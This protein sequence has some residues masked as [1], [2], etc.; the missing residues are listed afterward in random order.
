[1]SEFT[2]R[3]RQELANCLPHE[4]RRL[5]RKLEK[6]DGNN[7]VEITAIE[8]EIRQAVLR[9]TQRAASVPVIHFTMD[10]PIHHR[11]DDIR[12]AMEKHQVVVICG[13]TGSGKTT[14][15]PKL[16]LSM[17]RG[18]DGQI[19][20][21]QPRRIAAR[22][23]ATRIAEE[24]ATP[25]G[26]AVGF[27]IRHTD[28]T[29]DNT[30]IKLMTDGI[31]L[32]ELQ[33]DRKLLRYDTLIIDEAHER[34]LNIDFI[35]GYLKQLLPQRP[36]LKVI[37]T[38]A[39]IDVQR[40]SEHFNNAPVI[41]VSGRMYPVEVRYRPVEYEHEDERDD[42]AEQ[43]AI[44]NAVREL[45]Q[46]GHGDILIFL[47]G[48]REIHETTRFLEKQKLPDT[49]VLPLYARLSSARQAKIFQPH[50]RRHIVLATNVAET[51][52]TIPGIRYVIDGGYARISRYSRRAK[53]QQLPV[54][55]ISRAAAEQRKGRCGRVAEGTCIRLYSEDDYTTRPE[56]MDPEIVR[57]NL[58]A[59]I[60]QMK[61]L[62]FSDIHEFP[63]IDPPDPR[64]INDGLRLLNE[65][66]ALN[67]ADDL[68][69]IGKRLARLPLDPRLGR[70]LLAAHELG[71]VSEAVIIVSALSAQD[72]RER[73][74]DAQQQADEAHARFSD[75][76]SDF[77][78]LLNIWTFYHEQ[79][80]K[81]SQNQLRKLCQQ[82]F[83]SYVRIREWREIHKQLVQMLA[84][85]DIHLNSA[86]V[87]YDTLHRALLPGLLSHIAMKSDEREYTGARGI[88]LH[89]FPGSSQF[90]KLPKWIVAAEL[91]ETSKLYARTVAAIQP[92]WLI[93]P[94]AHLLQHEY[95]LPYWD[96]KSQQVLGY[97]KISLF[98]LVLAANQKINYGKVN[99]KEARSIFIRH[100]LVEN[101]LHTR[102]GFLQHNQAIIDGIKQLEHKSRR[103]D[104]YN[105][106]ALADFYDQHLPADVY[107]GPLF[108][109]W[110]GTVV[111]TNSEL[112]YVKRDDIIYHDAEHITPE[113][114]P[115]TLEINRNR[116][117]LNY[118][119]LPGQ[120]E[121]GVN[122]DVP[123]FLLNQITPHH[124][125]R[126][127]P[128][129]LEEK[130]TLMLRSLPKTIRRNLV[131]V[132]DTAKEC[133]EHLREKGGVLTEAL[134]DYLFRSRGVRINENDWQV[135]NMPDHLA[136][137]LRV[138]DENNK[139]LAQGR[140]L[141][142]LQEQ[143][144]HQSQAKFAVISS[145]ALDRDG[146]TRWDFG[147]LPE[148]IR[149]EINQMPV[150]AWP[151]LV[152][153]GNSVSLRSFDTAARAADSMRNGLR[154]LF[155]LEL[156]QEFKYLHKNLPKAKDITFAYTGLGHGEEI[157]NDLINLI[158]DAVFINDQAAIR[159]QTA[160]EQRKQAGAAKLLTEANRLCELVAGILQRHQRLQARLSDLEG[161]IPDG[162]GQD[163]H[164]QLSDLIYPGF[165]HQVDAAQLQHYSRYLEAVD[166]R[167]SKLGYAPDK[168]RTQLNK[169]KPFQDAW[170]LLAHTYKIRSDRDAELDE[171]HFMLEEYRVSLFAQEL[172]T[173][174]TVS[175]E[176]LQKRLDKIRQLPAAKGTRVKSDN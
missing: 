129:L 174:I 10:L 30:Y 17:G 134:A 121:D 61:A 146:I 114:Y 149:I 46:L 43:R 153:Q 118:Q 103:H 87:D 162:S 142:A 154:R 76:R 6:M 117:P 91:A 169:L 113:M 8:A 155:M 165:L 90:A 35:L 124:L 83:L 175:P 170:H 98:G 128:G 88:K 45:S 78:A 64:Y 58:A 116:L 2:N 42:E 159:T 135:T 96:S 72:P 115:D 163:I 136:F 29:S 11:L 112:L 54:E 12:Q 28:V 16:C 31:L 172:G 108:E 93:R 145:A 18:I 161:N 102:A 48:E 66:G 92:D 21:T 4:R 81:L 7:P 105:E 60:L 89:I 85:M 38:S 71:C 44:L 20:H 25:L 69:R 56:F 131:P 176:R 106:Q 166:R 130:V 57:T 3:Y 39:T 110:Y 50:R 19:G 158:A 164:N 99:P 168:D 77:I 74:L 41:E 123:V 13:E 15:L 140:D 125:D 36:D 68:T 70:I 53:V 107:N 126:L 27:K 137:N 138:V 94:A 127:V 157:K 119:F 22:T 14:Q 47:E 111:K 84:A 150:T 24:L 104:I 171:F 62:H 5:L 132:P 151:A 52:L 49:D 9:R 173:A 73:P 75:E 32:A 120:A 34:S 80:K 82:N 79:A 97:E 86:P 122:I 167:L 139:L 101:S 152:D 26:S 40:F 65:L 95:S 100:A 37:I 23:V 63:F 67:E 141:S 144:A 156:Q 160:F 133:V 147:D 59:V 143:F 33:Q 1:M 55:K 109:K 148:K 51:S